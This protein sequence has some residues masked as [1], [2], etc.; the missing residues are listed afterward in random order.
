MPRARARGTSLG[1]AVER[2]AAKASENEGPQPSYN[3]SPDQPAPGT[4]NIRSGKAPE[5]PMRP[6]VALAIGP[7]KTMLKS[8]RAQNVTT[9]ADAFSR[10][11]PEKQ[12]MQADGNPPLCGHL[13]T[14]QRG[15]THDSLPSQGTPSH[16]SSST[17]PPT[18]LLVQCQEEAPAITH[19]SQP[20]EA[21]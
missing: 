6:G 2:G 15:P 16:Y 19:H 20:G 13:L 4:V 3:T 11:G 7:T 8:R 14:F 9:P 17:R 5:P 12:R 18:P 1:G 10:F 21:A